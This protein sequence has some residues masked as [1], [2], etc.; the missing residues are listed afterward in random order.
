MHASAAAV[1]RPA[2]TVGPCEPGRSATVSVCIATSL[3][4]QQSAL[5]SP[6]IFFVPLEIPKG[7]DTG[8]R[9]RI[10]I[11][12]LLKYNFGEDEKRGRRS[13]EKGRYVHMF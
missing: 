2:T 1:T 7:T 8:L 3:E 4:P 11:L 6:T 10:L 5:I 12:I 13:R 9:F